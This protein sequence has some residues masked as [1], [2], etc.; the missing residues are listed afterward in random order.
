MIYKKYKNMNNLLPSSIFVCR[1]Y[2]DKILQKK[3]ELKI[4]LMDFIENYN[5]NGKTLPKFYG[6][7][8]NNYDG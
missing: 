8:G 2:Y 1:K 6:F 4:A 3:Q 7:S 5:N